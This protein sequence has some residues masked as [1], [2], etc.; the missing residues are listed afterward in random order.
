MTHATN[1][2]PS[3]D[4]SPARVVS[5]GGFGK[6]RTKQA[7]RMKNLRGL[8]RFWKTEA[9]Q[10]RKLF[11]DQ[12]GGDAFSAMQR[13]LCE[14]REKLRTLQPNPTLGSGQ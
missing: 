9:K 6:R 10:W 3:A 13:E 2:P 11:E 12:R 7:E 8:V 14:A 4:Q 5:G 1:N